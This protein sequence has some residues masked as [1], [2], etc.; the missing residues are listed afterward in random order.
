MS[1][2]QCDIP[3]INMTFTLAETKPREFGLRRTLFDAHVYIEE[4]TKR[5]E[6]WL[7]QVRASR[8][9]EDV[10]FSQGSGVE[11]EI[12]DEESVV[13]GHNSDPNSDVDSASVDYS[14]ETHS[15][16]RESRCRSR[17]RNRHK[18]RTLPL[19]ASHVHIESIIESSETKD[20]TLGH[21]DRAHDDVTRQDSSQSLA[22]TQPETHTSM[23]CENIASKNTN[24]Q[25]YNNAIDSKTKDTLPRAFTTDEF[26]APPSDCEDRASER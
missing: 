13:C 25:I 16:P 14:R 24:E 18:A 10:H 20:S 17:H 6:R 4:N 5:C 2:E 22:K 3:D 9:L 19:S 21:C 26:V 7:E 8:P 23:Q 11:L 12:P 15:L 1:I